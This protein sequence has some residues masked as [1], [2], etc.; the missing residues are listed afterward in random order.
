MIV[1]SRKRGLNV[2]GGRSRA[3]RTKRSSCVSFCLKAGGCVPVLRE[4]VRV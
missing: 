3:G 1:S 2:E 4:Y